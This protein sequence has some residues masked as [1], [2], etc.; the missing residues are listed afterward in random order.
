MLFSWVWIDTRYILVYTGCISLFQVWQWIRHKA[1]LEDDKRLVSKE[2]VVTL[3]SEVVMEL[4]GSCPSVRWADTAL[5]RTTTL[6]LILRDWTPI[7]WARW[8][9][10]W[11]VYCV[12]ANENTL[13]HEQ[14]VAPQAL[15]NS[16]SLLQ[17]FSAKQRLH[18]AADMFLEVVLKRDFPAFIT[19]YL[20]EEHTIVSAH[21]RS[22]VQVLDQAK[23]WSSFLVIIIS[24]L[25]CFC[26]LLI[27]QRDAIS[28]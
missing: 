17:L 10:W 22:P 15:I 21:Q 9:R 23:L 16:K 6:L 18:T 27:R 14:R 2:L 25:D 20:S 24:L 11:V 12:Q 19:T 26:A 1:E 4:S 28:E 3:A 5:T 7:L 8:W 13:L